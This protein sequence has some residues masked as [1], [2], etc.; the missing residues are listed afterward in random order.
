M[1]VQFKID[2][3]M[4]ADFLKYLFPPQEDGTLQVSMT[5]G[6]GVL[7]AIYAKQSIIQ[8]PPPIG[9]SVCSLNLPDCKVTKNLK[10]RWLYFDTHSTF[11]LNK[12]LKEYFAL[13]FSTY[14]QL[15]KGVH[16]KREI[17][18]AYIFSRKLINTDNLESL[19]KRAYRRE[20][21]KIEVIV[22]T[23]TRKGKYINESID[24]SGI[25]SKKH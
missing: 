11:L 8:M 7:F 19:Q 10:N 12:A 13:D 3:Q 21:T 5:H 18:E 9:A 17:I 24:R 23:L 2:G 14:L 6:L 22:N 25:Q 20:L 15:G 4:Y 1:T 16:K